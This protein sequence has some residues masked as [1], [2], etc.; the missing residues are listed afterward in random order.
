MKNLGTIIC[1]EK[2]LNLCDIIVQDQD[3]G[4]KKR[5]VLWLYE[6]GNQI[7]IVVIKANI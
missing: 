2:E 7:Y 5:N 6:A 3:D 1:V 4:S